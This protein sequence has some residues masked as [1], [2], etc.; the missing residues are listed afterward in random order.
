MWKTRATRAFLII[1]GLCSAGLS[2]AFAQATGTAGIV[3]D[4]F[5]RGYDPVT[6]S[7]AAQVGPSG[8][9]PADGPGEF[10]AIVPPVPGEY[11]WLDART[12]QFL[13]AAA[14]LPLRKYR[15]QGHGTSTSLVTM[16]VP[17]AAV[18]PSPGSTGLDPINSFTLDFRTD[19]EAADLARMITIEVRDLP[20]VSPQG[21]IVMSGS[22]IKVRALKDRASL[23]QVVPEKPI[24]F[25]KKAIMRLRLALDDSIP[26]SVASYSFSTKPEFSLV[27]MGAGT[28]RL[29][30]TPSGAAYS[31]EQA[32]N[33]GTENAPL[34]LEFSEAISPPS[35]EM[36]KRLVSFEPAVR[37]LA[38]STDG[39]RL[40]LKFQA[41][42]EKLYRMSLS[43]QAL[44]SASG[45]TLGR[46]AGASFSFYY[47]QASPY[48]VW[49]PAGGIAE[50]FGP[51]FLPMEGRG[52]GRLD[53]RV[54]K[55]SPENLEFWP[56]PT[57]AVAVDETARPPMP[58]EEQQSPGDVV[59]RIRLLGSPDIS[60]LIDLPIGE[61]SVRSSFG[62]DLRQI[63]AARFGAGAPGTFLVGY[64]SLDSSAQR[65][66]VRLTVTD[67]ALS[68]V[69]EEDSVVFVVTS[70]QTGAPVAGASIRVE[71]R[72]T[73]STGGTPAMKTL[74]SGTTDQTG[75]YRYRHVA[76]LRGT[77]ARIL[78]QK[79]ADMLVLD[80]RSPPPVFANNHWSQ[81]PASW[82]AWVTSD[83]RQVR[84]DRRTRAY[85]LTERPVYRPE[86][87]VHV[88]GWVRDRKDG[89]IL[90]PADAGT[91]VLIVSGPGG[92]EWRYNAELNGNGRFYFEFKE[93]NLPTGGY[94][95]ALR[96]RSEVLASVGFRKESYR[97]PTFEIA[98][99]GP[100]KVSL[101]KPFEVVLTADYYAGGRVVG[102]RVDWEVTRSPYSITNPSYPGFVFST[103]ERFSAA[104]G[105]AAS[106]VLSQSAKLDDDG[107]AKIRVNPAAE[108]DARARRYSVRATVQG[109]DRQTVTTVKQVFALPS[110]SIGLGMDRFVT[111][112]L[113]IKPRIIVLD[114]QENPLA[115][116]QLTVRL[117]QRQ[118]HSYIA[119]TD[120][121]TGEA[122]YVTDV[123]DAR[124]T[125][126]QLISTE[127]ELA[128]S[129]PVRE[130]GVYVVEVSGRDLLGRQISVKS[131]LF[132]AGSTPVSW[133]RKK[134]S[135]FDI[136]LDKASYQPGMTAKVLFRSPYQ[137]GFALVVAEG[138]ESNT[139]AWVKV[140][141]GQG[142]YQLPITAAMAPGVPLS[143]LLERG[144]VE[145]TGEGHP[146]QDLG[147]PAS[148]GASTWL[149]VQPVAN[150]VTLTLTHESRRQ[151]GT[152]LPIHIAL[153]DW[154]GNALDGEVALW[155][156]DRAVLSLGTEPPLTPLAPFIEKSPSAL[157]L[158]D[159]RNLV[160]GNLP[161]EEV[162][163][164]DG[165]MDMDLLR[166]LMERTTV[167][168]NFKTVPYF[169]PAIP[170]TGGEA[171]IEVSLPDNLTDFAIRA[172]AVCGYDR[173][174]A[175]RSA[176]SVRLPVVAQSALP[177][178]V[179]PGDSFSAGGIGRIAEGPDGPGIAG[180]S[181]EGLALNAANPAQASREITFAGRNAQKLLFPMSVPQT[182]RENGG[183]GVA[184]SFFVERLSDKARDAFRIELPVRSDTEQR[185]ITQRASSDGS[186]T[187]AMPDPPEPFREGTL[188]RRIV[189]ARDPRVIT[190]IQGLSYLNDYAYGCV[191]Q[192]VSK[193]SPVVFLKE[194]L[195]S[196]GLSKIYPVNEPAFQETFTY[197][198]SCIDDD[199]LYGYWP[200]S[201]GVV[202]LTAY[203]TEF[204]LACRDAN[205][206]FDQKLLDR[207]IAALTRALRSDYTR[208]LSG[209]SSYERVEAL[210]ALQAAG[211]LDEGYANDLLASATGLPL[212]S[213]ARLYLA[214]RHSG[215][216]DSGRM[217]DLAAA[218]SAGVVT[219]MEGSREIF[220]GLQGAPIEWGGLVLS[221][222]LKTVAAVTQVLL[223]ANPGSPRLGM[224]TDYLIS[225]SG[226]SGWGN[227]QDNMAGLKAMTALL[228]SSAA[229][230]GEIV[231]EVSQAKGSRRLST[232][233]KGLAVFT[234]D[235]PGPLTLSVRK[236][237]ARDQPL[238]LILSVDYLPA[239]RGTTARAENS[240]FAAE[241]E[242]ITI[243]PRGA[244]TDHFR[245]I[246]GK[247]IELPL[248]TVVEEHARVVNFE[249][250]TFVAVTV[251]IAAGL[252]PLNPNLAGA[253]P[254]ATPRGS[255]TLAPTYSV[256]GDEAVTFYYNALP[257]GNYDFYF[258]A[259]ASFGGSFTEPPVRA[260]LL[261]NL[262]VRGRSDGCELS[263]RPAAE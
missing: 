171:D 130:A 37:D 135:V 22:D 100:D 131:D 90:R 212:Y 14:W 42:R 58:G 139:Y 20:G 91:F 228:A 156:V 84:H 114:H 24:P 141:D 239:A 192:R 30:V 138:P 247:A 98:L 173:F 57:Q 244:P 144:R 208:L 163:G 172:V 66:Y 166:D 132:V 196:T 162:A 36:V 94:T 214:L 87:T 121:T 227:T 257:K 217:R 159:T 74:F 221:S 236:G 17:P 234:L 47:T 165:T 82:L 245:A 122:R 242:L 237:A 183:A 118:W 203:A 68:T 109:A 27:A 185:R 107:S 111:N 15:I 151:P 143:V 190:L 129:F 19:L 187:L 154:K 18:T 69:E 97:V 4:R 80:P 120:F 243:G 117:L 23:F 226:P 41:D 175:A 60:R 219:K 218:I 85:I 157:R 148:L 124:L 31:R 35:L 260:E 169:N 123:V 61:Q 152:R 34:F 48:I 252:E 50:R 102:E 246:T 250:R 92:K 137:E 72:M 253:S 134:A 81:G 65:S 33:C 229:G 119:E 43:F 73:D 213:Q 193:L 170:V 128:P 46:F 67:L 146:R 116:K 198:A 186:T 25:G 147:K 51:Q 10:L 161:V 95:A 158:R 101:D 76:A 133:E 11:R 177:R 99:S 251:P 96:N 230:D 78:V 86:E 238:S 168:K 88:L 45:R 5:L 206:P 2:P 77:P 255:L 194:L 127:Q 174:G 54:Y 6:I 145:G 195:E 8:G 211:K 222:E 93:S 112:S 105:S 71:T 259:R 182:L 16:M 207:P 201:P 263:I 150:Q 79:D 140:S 1:C 108:G 49:K 223:S 256:Y 52:M 176:V 205:I 188:S 40:T 210:A 164:G 178:F 21:S 199:G 220:A 200:G 179:R 3:P 249:D 167:R 149:V 225:R 231:L 160:L 106:G 254:E 38:V 53:L 155:L 44:A 13:P 191:E 261:Y 32:I 153:R 62:I 189:V 110:F 233:G 59:S 235:D 204:L 184:V 181:V 197:M 216:V 215:L 136:T 55:V 240:G 113:E 103:D 180:I 241:R 202:S 7:Y 224:L 28:V 104:D 258:R 209:Y 70:L 115:G 142:I 64:R 83:P 89:K 75:Q 262:D 248:D 126:T 63:L 232:S 39:K 12:I 9:G 56:F 125:E 26:D 29:P